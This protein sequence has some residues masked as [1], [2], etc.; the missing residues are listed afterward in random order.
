M[1]SKSLIAKIQEAISKIQ[2]ENSEFIEKYSKI[3]D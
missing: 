1:K 3:N 2:M